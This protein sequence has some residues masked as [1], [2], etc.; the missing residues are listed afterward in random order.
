MQK[1]KDKPKSLFLIAETQE[2]TQFQIEITDDMSASMIMDELSK[3]VGSG[4]KI[5]KSDYQGR[6]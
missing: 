3:L 6:G 5:M 2:K 1:L 4:H